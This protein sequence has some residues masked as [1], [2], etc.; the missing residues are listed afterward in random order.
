[1]S[2][3]LSLCVAG[4]HARGSWVWPT[5]Q[6]LEFGGHHSSARRR[7]RLQCWMKVSKRAVAFLVGTRVVVRRGPS[8]ARRLLVPYLTLARGPRVNRPKR[9]PTARSGLFSHGQPTQEVCEATRAGAVAQDVRKLQC[10]QHYTP[11]SRA[12]RASGTAG[13]SRARHRHRFSK[14]PPALRRD[15]H[16]CGAAPTPP[17]RRSCRLCS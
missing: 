1:M 7:Y 2:A 9:K 12:R 14:A 3:Q 13:A 16:A 10:S 17:P 5:T 6:G 4:P 8:P 11:P 15:G